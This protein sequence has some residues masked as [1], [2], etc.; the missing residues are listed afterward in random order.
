MLNNTIHYHDGALYVDSVPL[1]NI[2]A[3]CGTPVYVYSQ[4]RAR[5]NLER[6][7]QA[8]A[9]MDAH[10]HYSAKANA[11]LA[12]LRTLVAAGAGVDAVSGGE[13]YRA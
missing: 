10:I 13:I 6:I 12:I 9:T 11:N 4:R 2:A 3:A 5:A 1:A 7:R 8:F